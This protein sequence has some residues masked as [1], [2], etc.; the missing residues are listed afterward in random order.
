MDMNPKPYT[1]KPKPVVV[2]AIPHILARVSLNPYVNIK[3]HAHGPKPQT[4][5]TAGHH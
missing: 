1:L 4:L 3:P 2:V 5:R